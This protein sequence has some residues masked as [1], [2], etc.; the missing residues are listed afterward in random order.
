[1]DA[2]DIEGLLLRNSEALR[3]YFRATE[4]GRKAKGFMVAMLVLAVYCGAFVVW[5][6]C[7]CN[8]PA[9]CGCTRA[10]GALTAQVVACVDCA[11]R[12]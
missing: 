2:V 6:L 5:M 7:A 4:E 11:C 3:A 12:R 1:M 9:E 8:D 10:T